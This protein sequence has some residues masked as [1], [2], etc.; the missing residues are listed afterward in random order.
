MSGTSKNGVFKDR[1][2]GF[3]SESRV[4]FFSIEQSIVAYY[5]SRNLQQSRIFI[6]LAPI[7]AASPQ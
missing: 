6:S 7:A 1:I 3:G 5:M 2:T 4:V